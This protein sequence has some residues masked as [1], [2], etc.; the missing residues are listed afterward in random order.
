MFL[1]VGLGN[2]G[3]KYANQRHNIGFVVADEIV[4]RHGFSAW[5]KRFNG[6][7]SEGT[8]GG[9]RVMVLKPMTYMNESGNSVG[10]AVRFYG[11]EPSQIIVIHDE[12]DLAPGKVRVKFGG[13]TAGHNGLKSIG[14]HI[15]PHFVRVRIGIGHPGDRNLVHPHVLS[16]FSKA[17]RDWAKPVVEA[18]A[19]A[20]PLLLDGQDGSFQ[21]KVHLALNPETEKPPRK[22]QE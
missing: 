21:N 2:P 7:V 19:E 9:E 14:A 20:M 13:G 15:G 1:I 17:E 12:L 10:A 11:L 3:P 8:I 16:D 4:S 18:I 22:E 6:E 5:R